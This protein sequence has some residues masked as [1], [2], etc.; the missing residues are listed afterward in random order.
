MARSARRL[1]RFTD[2]LSIGGPDLRV[3]PFCLGMVRA[4]GTVAAAFEAGINF[5]FLTADMHWPLYEASRRG[6]AALIAS[7]PSVR[8][9]IVVAVACYPTQ[10]EFCSIPFNEVLQAVPRLGRIDV[11]VIGGAYER[12][13]AA[14]L[15]VY[16]HHRTTRHAGIAAIGASFHDRRA[17]RTAIDGAAVDVAF[18]RYNASHPGAARD[19]FPHLRRRRRRPPI[20]NFTTTNGFVLPRRIAELGLGRDYWRP[21]VTDHY[22]FALSRPEIA[23][24]LC[25][26][27][28]PGQI[29][30]LGRALERGPLTDEE[31]RYL[32][33]LSLL[34]QG[35]A[36][37]QR[38]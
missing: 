27:A 26:P 11:A 19:L 22:R 21:D 38:Q 3:S 20:F 30:T 36:R 34:D 14:R 35:R 2:R 18:I 17:A 32:T 13:F 37:L 33:D 6:L 10:P 1:P 25:S 7:R 29:A 28:T 8:D 31:Q 4:P 24:L 9:R 5:F 12:D 16:R 15:P 23:G